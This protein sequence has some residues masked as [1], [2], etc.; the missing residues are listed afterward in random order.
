MAHSTLPADIW[1]IRERRRIE[2][3]IYMTVPPTGNSILQYYFRAHTPEDKQ[4]LITGAA[5]NDG[6][7]LEND[8]DISDSNSETSTAG[9]HDDSDQDI[10]TGELEDLS[11][12][13]AGLSCPP[14]PSTD[15]SS[16]LEPALHPW[17]SRD[18]QPGTDRPE[19]AVRYHNPVL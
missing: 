16:E 3:L 9:A 5:E 15:D 8:E 13:N 4:D 17:P 2:A 10:S 7:Y 1:F 12:E 18:V 6:D 11:K 19:V 14:E